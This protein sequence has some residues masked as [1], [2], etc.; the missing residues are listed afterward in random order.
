MPTSVRERPEPLPYSPGYSPNA[1][2]FRPNSGPLSSRENTQRTLLVYC[3]TAN[4]NCRRVSPD[5]EP[6]VDE[7][8][9][10]VAR[11]LHSPGFA[12]HYFVGDGLDVGSGPDPLARFA[13][14]FPLIR[15]V[16]PF[17]LPDGDAQL[18]AKY[19]ADRFDFLH[20]SHCLEHL[21]DPFEG[22]ANWVRVV[23]PGGHLVV[24]V[25]DEDLYEQGAWPSTFNPDHKH[26]F[27]FCKVRSWS[28]VS[29]N[30]TDLLASVADR[31]EVLK[32]EVLY[33]TF[34]PGRG[35]GDQTQNPV[36]ECA[37]EFVLRKRATTLR[38]GG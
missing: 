1:P 35:R 17:D 23:R 4:R 28:P 25:P 18:L 7:C 33:Q 30:L 12:T 29:V 10:A 11:R 34:L 6:H 8:S 37:I 21:H 3:P 2:L 31:A 26:T 36:G 5:G 16:V 14:L 24:L 22:L 27:T 38:S 19:P 15:S 32:V 9:K 20:S 13:A